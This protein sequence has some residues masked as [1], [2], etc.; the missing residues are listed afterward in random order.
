[1]RITLTLCFLFL[2]KIGFAINVD[3]LLNAANKSDDIEEKLINWNK[4]AWHLHNK[5]LRKSD[6]LA[7]LAKK[8]AEKHNVN[9][10]L[11]TALNTLATVAARRG[12]FEKAINTFKPAIDK[13]K[14][15]KNY[16]SYL[17]SKMNLALIWYFQGKLDTSI[18]GLEE[19]NIEAKKY[20]IED[21]RIKN[22]SNLGG[23]C[24]ESGDLVKSLKY[25][26]EC[27]E[28]LNI[29]SNKELYAATANNV[30]LLYDELKDFDRA[31]YYHFIS[32]KLDKEIDNLA[33]IGDSYLN[34]GEI[35]LQES[36][37]DSACYYFDLA[38][39]AGSKTGDSL[40]IFGIRS[41]QNY[42]RI[43]NKE[44]KDALA[45]AIFLYNK[46]K[47]LNFA[48]LS[49]ISASQIGDVY[50]ETGDFNESIKY[51]K[52]SNELAQKHQIGE[53]ITSSYKGLAEAYE[54]VNFVDSA[55]YYNKAHQTL[56]DS[57]QSFENKQQIN[58]MEYQFQSA[59]KEKEIIELRAENTQMAL[60]NTKK[61]NLVI[62]LISGVLLI[63]MISF[64][65]IQLNK[66][67]AEK[68][69]NA[70][71]VAEKQRGI[72]S[73]IFAQEG[74]R[75]R[76]AKDLHDGIGQKLSGMKMSMNRAAKEIEHSD[77]KSRL[78]EL[79]DILE[80]T[81]EEIRAI[82]HKM[83]P[84]ALREVG[85]SGA[86]KSMLEKTFKFSDINYTY[87]EVNVDGRFPEKLEVTIYRIAQELVNNAIK[88]AEATEI[89][90]QLLKTKGYLVLIVQ[91]D[92]K[93]VDLEDF[94]KGQGFMNISSRLSVNEGEINLESKK[95]QGLFAQVRI[96][97]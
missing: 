94:K 62:L 82:S 80:V 25:F 81:A 14:Q 86:L 5:D 54:K 84:I 10:H 92:G 24:R 71:I 19:V 21:V 36:K 65:I 43:F 50:Y 51:Y 85:I 63:S 18:A 58:F 70:A 79:S 42:C 46:G 56:K 60:E 97:I 74:E 59:E 61:Q 11:A 17:N 1:M 44:Y 2:L 8:L 55:L 35:F 96:K 27:L 20:E 48:Y 31:R 45:E 22:L 75:K 23:I 52:L 53:V 87:D 57:V 4:A 26:L 38:Y 29:D 13:Y 34:L 40:S 89:N 16:R 39:E 90:V 49:S 72:E 73:I 3:S 91:D 41:N 9:L 12:E 7:L 83:M 68:A 76:I 67:K 69:K 78:Q 47:S 6:S 88:H 33:G 95:D 30:A 93:G 32:L 66:R 28:Q 77:T 37:E 64:A 15:Q